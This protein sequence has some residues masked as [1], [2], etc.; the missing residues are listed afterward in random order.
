VK[1]VGRAPRHDKDDAV[2]WKREAIKQRK[3]LVE[4]TESV[5]AFLRALDDEMKTPSTAERGRR[6][7]QLSNTLE[8]VNDHARY[9]ALGVD[10][11]TAKKR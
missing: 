2:A 4:V 5:H 1:K 10:Y 9:F 6:V 8:L 3:A 7:A 11:R